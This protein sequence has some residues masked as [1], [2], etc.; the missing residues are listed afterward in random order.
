MR[1]DRRFRFQQ[2]ECLSGCLLFIERLPVPLGAGQQLSGHCNCGR[3][4][5]D[6]HLQ[7]ARVL[8]VRRHP[9]L[10]LL[11]RSCPGQRLQ[12]LQFRVLL[13]ISL[14]PA[15]R[16][17]FQVL[18]ND[19]EVLRAEQGLHDF[20]P[21]AGIR[22]QQ[23]PK[24][25]LRQQDDLPELIAPKSENTFHFRRD[26]LRFFSQHRRFPPG[27]IKTEQAGALADFHQTGAPLA[28]SLLPGSAPNPVQ[29]VSHRK[30]KRHFRGFRF[31]GI[32]TAHV[33]PIAHLA[34]GFAVKR[35]AHRIQQ[36]RL[37]G[38]GRSMDQK[39]PVLP[40]FGKID[41]LLGGIGS[42]SMNIQ[43]QR[44]HLVPSPVCPFSANNV[45]MTPRWRSESGF[46]VDH[47]ANDSKSSMPD[48][49]RWSG[50]CP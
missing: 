16:R 23:A 18:F 9:L 38:P 11:Q 48:R 22:Q 50:R 44:P 12:L 14:R 2:R 24:L 35:I 42:E 15:F 21:F 31:S 43:F 17:F 20:L 28:G 32:V 46:A 4:F 7:G 39:K 36:R 10:Q 34:A 13:H 25:P 45:C 26:F 1:H 8:F 3:R 40:E 5:R 27:I 41:H 49:V 19:A 29:G 33:L 30:I 37:A 6:L 47:S